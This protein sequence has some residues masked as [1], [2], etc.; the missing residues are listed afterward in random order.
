MGG[1]AENNMYVVGQNGVAS[2]WNGVD[3]EILNI[4]RE[5]MPE[6]V[7]LTGIWT[8]GQEAFICGTDG[9]LTYILHGR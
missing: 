7:W 3:W 1:N 5:E 6:N 4:P 2:H 8:D 9:H